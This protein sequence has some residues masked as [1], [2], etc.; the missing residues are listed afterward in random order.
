M[1]H[2]MDL[3]EHS[4]KFSSQESRLTDMNTVDKQT[5]TTAPQQSSSSLFI[6]IDESSSGNVEAP[7]IRSSYF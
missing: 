5:L 7:S 6:L 1:A 3:E 4:S 2:E